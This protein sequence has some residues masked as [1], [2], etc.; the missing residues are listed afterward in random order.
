MSTHT[1]GAPLPSGN[2]RSALDKTASIDSYSGVSLPPR[3][4]FFASPDAASQRR[5]RG[6][7]AWKF[8]TRTF[9]APKQDRIPSGNSRISLYTLSG[10][11]GSKTASRSLTVWP[12]VNA[13]KQVVYRSSRRSDEAAFAAC[14]AIIIPITAVLPDPVAIRTAWRAI[15]VVVVGVRLG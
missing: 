10:L 1:F 9:T 12:G 13:R 7:N 11:D 14:Q 6:A 15:P 8:S 3:I 4:S 2:P 5:S